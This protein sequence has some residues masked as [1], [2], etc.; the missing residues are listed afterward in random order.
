MTTT[1]TPWWS[2]V[3][4]QTISWS[5][6]QWLSRNEGDEVTD[7]TYTEYFA[8]SSDP[9]LAVTWRD[10]S[11]KLIDFVAN[12]ATFR[13]ELANREAPGT[14]V[15][16]KTT[17]ITG[18][19]TDPNVSIAW[20]AVGELAGLAPGFYIGE[21]TATDTGTTKKR[22]MPVSLRIMPT[23]TAWPAP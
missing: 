18:V 5:E 11:R 15:V 4:G 19:A 10:R 13:L 7:R 6:D 23:V 21:L 12:P 17:G 20:A 9:A 22:K 1:D 16:T 3:E 8:G 2:H 14:I